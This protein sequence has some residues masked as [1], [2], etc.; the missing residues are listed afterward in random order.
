MMV[1]FS[2]FQ[3]LFNARATLSYNEK[4]SQDEDK[5]TY[6]RHFVWIK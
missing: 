3:M 6:L 2:F 5:T 4:K 1:F